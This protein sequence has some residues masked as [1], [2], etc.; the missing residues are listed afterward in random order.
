M[1]TATKRKRRTLA[2]IG[3]PADKANM[4]D[5]QAATSLL[6]RYATGDDLRRDLRM[7]RQLERDAATPS[8][9][10]F[11]ACAAKA[12]RDVL[13]ETCDVYAEMARLAAAEAARD[14]RT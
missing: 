6:A 14:A 9:F 8:T 1:T 4:A 7:L 10:T 2:S 12:V 13:S 3:R 11:F 5:W